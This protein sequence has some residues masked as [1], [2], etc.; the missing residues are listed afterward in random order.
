MPRNIFSSIN[1]TNVDNTLRVRQLVVGAHLRLYVHLWLEGMGPDMDCKCLPWHQNRHIILFFNGEKQHCLSTMVEKHEFL[2]SNVAPN[3]L[4]I[5][6]L[7]IN[8]QH[9]ICNTNCC[10]LFKPKER[11]MKTVLFIRYYR[12]SQ[13]LDYVI[14]MYHH[15]H[16]IRTYIWTCE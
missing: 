7:K 14:L 2:P 16:G 11:K 9:K 4:M 10:P 8:L 1:A 13:S 15:I 5:V 6:H 3:N 12:S